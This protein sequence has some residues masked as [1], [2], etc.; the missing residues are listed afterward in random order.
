VAF[1]S[2]LLGGVPALDRSPRGR[3]LPG[4]GRR[5]WPLLLALL[6]LLAYAPC[7]IAG[8]LLGPGDG[9]ALHYPLR[10]AVWQ[11]YRGGELPSWNPHVFLGTPLLGA[12]RPGALHPLMMVLAALPDFAA[13]QVLVLVSLA[14]AGP[15]VFFYLRRLGADAVSAYCA[16]LFYA[17]GPYLVGHLDDTATVVAAPLLPALLLAAERWIA[18]GRARSAA[19]T[20]LV[21][22]LLLLA[23]S[24]EAAR[25]GAALLAG[26]VLV[27]RLWPGARPRPS[28]PAI[29]LVAAGALLLAAPQLVPALLAAREAGRPLTGLGNPQQGTLPG[30][31]GL[32]IRYAAHT[33]APALALA[34]VPLLARHLAVRVLGAALAISLALQWGRGPLAAPGALALVFDLSLCVLS[35]LCLSVLWRQRRSP[36]GFR[37]RAL[38]LAA[39]LVSAAALSVATVSLGPL[40]ETLQGA[41]GTLALALILYFAN[42]TRDGIRARLWL[43]PLTVAFLLQPHGR[44]VWEGTPDERALREGSA[45]RQ[46]MTR[47]MEARAGEPVLTL[48]REW[49]GPDAD[50]LAYANLGGLAGRRNVNGYDPMVSLRNRAALGAMSVGGVLPAG[51][52]QSD[53]GR[54][55]LLGVRWVQVP[56]SVLRAPERAREV[57]PP[58]GLPLVQPRFFA[59]PMTAA[60]GVRIVSSLVNAAAVPQDQV[61]AFAHLRLASGRGEFSFPVRAGVHTAEWAWDRPDVRAAVQHQ[62]PAPAESWPA[63]KEGFS[64][65]H[66]LGELPLPGVYFVDGLRLEPVSGPFQLQVIRVAVVEA[67]TGRPRPLSPA[68]LYVSDATRLREVAA[69]PTVRLFE[70]PRTL[71]PARVAAAL[72]VLPDD[73]AVLEALA[74]PQR[75]GVD[76]LRDVLATAADAAGLAVPPGA[77]ASRAEVLNRSAGRIDVRAEGPGVLVLADSYDPGW[78]ARLDG[79]PARLLR[80]NHAQ[81]GLVLPPGPHRLLLRYHPRGWGA[82]L[83]LFALGALGLLAVALRGRRAPPARPAAQG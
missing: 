24:P 45:T 71:G 4:L 6:P 56:V 51:F 58:L 35:G 48:A 41:V 46:A 76:P 17:L 57:E 22:A 68:A 61:V 29:A 19:L 25:A 69:T 28:L 50:D 60:R 1:F 15:L 73:R 9:A 32:I 37:L 62:R 39:C 43:L 5:P 75:S 66:Y 8:G 59:F 78:S 10:A 12:Y 16:G 72:R 53:P 38:F 42:A 55:E 77:K 31:T 44:R 82:G 11:A 40:P 67:A 70:V 18:D 23:G 36:R 2:T 63:G 54:L 79:A 21:M 49:P 30:L 74:Q 7:W 27:A 14:L 81:A 3:G 13:F 20:A 26:R 47:A 52:F 65:H 83:A 34:S 33:P 80:V 64:G